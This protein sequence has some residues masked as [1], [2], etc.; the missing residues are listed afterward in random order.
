MKWVHVGEA[1]SVLAIII[2]S[3]IF[4]AYGLDFMNIEFKD[5]WIH[6]RGIGGRW[7]E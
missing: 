3:F 4:W 5:H 6:Q 1:L 7:D 2:I